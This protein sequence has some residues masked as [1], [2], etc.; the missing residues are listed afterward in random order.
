[1]VVTKQIKMIFDNVNNDENINS[2]TG[3]S[4]TISNSRVN[5]FVKKL[6]AQIF[7]PQTPE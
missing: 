5:A 1:M 6:N 3:N 7:S 4:L 2:D